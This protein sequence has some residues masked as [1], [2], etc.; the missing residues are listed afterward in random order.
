MSYA[1]NTTVSIDRS[2]GEIRKILSKY[3]AT[4]FAF[5]ETTDF[6]VVQFEMSGR[7]IRFMLPN[8]VY[9]KFLNAKKYIASEEQVSQENRRRWRCLTLIIKSKLEAVETGITTIE[10]E[11]MAHIVLPNGQTVGQTMIPQIAQSY[12]DGNMPPLLGYN[13]Q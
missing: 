10:E 6:S 7:R 4:G 5:G 12:S 11:F 1:K 13:P 2:Q 9:S 8:A 3:K